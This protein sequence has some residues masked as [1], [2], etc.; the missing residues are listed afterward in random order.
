MT[1]QG[2]SRIEAMNTQLPYLLALNR[3]QQLSPKVLFDLYHRYPNLEELFRLSKQDLH[4]QGLSAAVIEALSQ[5]D[6]TAIEKD[7]HWLSLSNNHHLID[8]HCAH[9]PALLKEIPDPPILLYAIGSIE[10][11]QQ[12]KLAI[13]GTRKPSHAGQENA[14]YFASEIS[15]QGL[16]I[17]SGLALGIDAA[18]HLGC[19]KACGSTIAVLGTGIDYIYPRQHQSLAF[20]ISETGLLLSE[21]PLKTPPIARHFPRRNRIISGLSLS[22]LVVEAAIRSGSLITARMALEQNRDVLAIPGSIH[23]P[24]ARGCHY[25]LQQG[26]KLVTCVEDVLDELNLLPDRTKQSTSTADHTVQGLLSFIDFDTTSVDQLVR[27]SG[28]TVQHITAE[29]AQLELQGAI[30]SVPGGYIRC[31]HER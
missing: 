9:Y 7:L 6:W 29:L 24:L 15:K 11:L 19:L 23:N 2:I 28:Y 27:R 17:V 31:Y 16:C 1:L 12:P 21:F 14:Q 20:A 13:V 26:A 30:I 8:L 10:C 18:A 5:I 3:S 4:K 25:L 22:I